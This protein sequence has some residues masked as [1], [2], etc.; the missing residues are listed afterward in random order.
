MVSVHID[1]R[2]FIRTF[3]RHCIHDIEREVEFIL[4]LEVNAAED[5]LFI[6]FAGDKLLCD[7]MHQTGLIDIGRVILNNMLLIFRYAVSVRCHDKRIDLAVLTAERDLIM[8][9]RAVIIDAVALMQDL[10]MRTD[11][12]PQ[13]ALDD[14]IHFLSGV[15]A[16]M[17]RSGERLLRVR[18]HN[19]E[20]LHSL[21]LELR[22]KAVIDKALS[23]DDRHALALSG[24]GIAAQLRAAA[25]HQ[26]GNLNMKCICTFINK[27]KTE[28]LFA[29]FI[30]LVVFYGIIRLG[31]HFLNRNTEILTQTGNSLCNL[32]DSGFGILKVLL[33]AH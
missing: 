33:V 27:R 20:R 1:H 30:Q 31:S 8:R 3:L 23:A 14:D 2:G 25:L 5:A 29:G 24:D 13:S 28:I 6:C 10:G 15:A 4:M 22:S 18:D 7:R 21:V 19:M 12:M 32:F 17:Q 16:E 11:D 26:F 9:D